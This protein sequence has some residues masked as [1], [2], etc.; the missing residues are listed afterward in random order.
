[1]DQYV[2]GSMIKKLRESRNMTQSELAERLYVSDKAISKWE[3]GK[4]Y[5]DI[6]LIEDLA[7]VLGVS[8][9]ELMSGSD[10]MNTNRTFNMQRI[11]F[12]VCPICGNVIVGTGE[13][14]ISCHGITLSPLQAEE[15]DDAHRLEIENIEDEY[16]VTID[17]EMSKGHYISF[18]A[19]VRDNGYEFIKLY[20]EGAAEARLKISR[21][22]WIYYFCNHHDLYRVRVH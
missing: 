19:A 14:M 2:I 7:K 20:P 8:V 3:T 12:Y 10:I 9:A 11:N 13:S 22:K 17:H 6:S 21:T 4:G 16:Y 5:P 1:M 18:I 15:P